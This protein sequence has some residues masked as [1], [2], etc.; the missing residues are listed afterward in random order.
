MSLVE[1]PNPSTSLNRE[2]I[3]DD[4]AM[5]SSSP[6]EILHQP[7][8]GSPNHQYESIPEYLLT[9][10]R[11]HH[12]PVIYHKFCQQLDKTCSVPY[13]TISRSY[14]LPREMTTANNDHSQCTCP[15]SS[16]TSGP[17]IAAEESSTPLL[18]SSLPKESQKIKNPSSP[19]SMMM[20]WSKRS[21]LSSSK[22]KPSNN[23]G[24]ETKMSF[25]SHLKK[26]TF[27]K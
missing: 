10:T 26:P 21:S 15:C 13:T 17:I 20:E 3:P 6:N 19:K 12:S 22:R 7:D 23:E 9:M 5:P 11:H 2:I 25:F 4:Q 16:I 14:L 1:P 27:L 8:D 18:C 24:N